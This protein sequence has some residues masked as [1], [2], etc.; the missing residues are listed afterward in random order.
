TGARLEDTRNELK[1]L[2]IPPELFGRKNKHG[3]WQHLARYSEAA[4]GCL[5]LQCIH[6]GVLAVVQRDSSKYT[7][8]SSI[9]DRV[10]VCVCV[11]CG[12]CFCVIMSVC[13]CVSCVD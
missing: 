4:G 8:L 1:Q 7:A 9:A 13:V 10:C 5:L 12:L 3:V 6:V 11:M 2:A